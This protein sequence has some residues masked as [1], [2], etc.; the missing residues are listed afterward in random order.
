[1]LLS[2]IVQPVVFHQHRIYCLLVEG[3]DRFLAG[4]PPQILDSYGE[5][6][7]LHNEVA[8]GSVVRVH[9]VD[10]ELRTVQLI[11]RKALN[12]FARAA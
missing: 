5:T 2:R 10:D 4:E 8:T 12:P 9:A 11:Q 1:M 7:V 6:I 3:H